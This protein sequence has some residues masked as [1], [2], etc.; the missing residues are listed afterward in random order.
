MRR[1]GVNFDR[2]MSV[3]AAFCAGVTVGRKKV[4]SINRKENVYENIMYW[5]FKLGYNCSGR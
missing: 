2:K 4:I 5:A 3:A 1:T